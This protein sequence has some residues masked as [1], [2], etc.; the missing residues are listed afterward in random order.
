MNTEDTL[1]A[2]WLAG[3][4]TPDEL[5]QLRK[6]V[7][8]PSLE[9]ILKQQ[10][11][12]ELEIQPTE[13]MWEEFE[14]ENITSTKKEVPK[15][16]KWWIWAILGLLILGGF[17]FYFSREKEQKIETPPA[18]TETKLFADGTQIQVSPGSSVK[19]NEGNWNTQRTIALDGQAF[20]D[21]EKGSPFIVT[22]EQGKIEVL[23]TQF[24]VWEMGDRM[25]VQCY[26]G[27]VKISKGNSSVTLSANQQ[28]FVNKN[29]VGS[30]EMISN[31]L[32][33]WMQQQRTYQKMPLRWVLKDIERFYDVKTD[34]SQ[35]SLDDDFGG[36]IKTDDLNKALD[37]LT[38][39]I[40][41]NYE[42][43]DKTI[44]FIP[45]KE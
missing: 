25:R 26:E 16:Q 4:I 37:Y 11:K 18:K 15:K 33:D 42:I 23:G 45:A 30:V 9:K 3:N 12:L 29:R 36:V 39:S 14:K 34:A 2:K 35:V 20:F 28:V 7:D 31:N 24:D 27:R 32:P 38:R 40:N 6:E 1:L 44:Y 22:T 5:E 41:W 17:W 10:E 43:K 19:F 13:M 8:L 21:V